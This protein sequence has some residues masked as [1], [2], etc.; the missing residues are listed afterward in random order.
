MA[1]PKRA[2]KAKPAHP[3]MLN[4]KD[5]DREKTMAHICDQLATS[6]RGL[7]KILASGY[8]G[9]RMPTYTAVMEWLQEE[10]ALAERYARAKEAQADFMADEI[11]EIADEM[12]PL[13]GDGKRMDSAHVSWQKNRIDARKWAAAKL[14]PK[15]YGDKLELG[16]SVGVRH[17]DALAALDDGDQ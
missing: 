17:E 11:T 13:D 10:P 14:R 2:Q 16:G 6:S 3:L 5:W 12:P 8:E 4:G 1:A 15:K 9:L 7:G